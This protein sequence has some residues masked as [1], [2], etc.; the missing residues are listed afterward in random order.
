MSSDKPYQSQGLEPD[1]NLCS[2]CEGLLSKHL[3]P[4]GQLVSLAGIVLDVYN[5]DLVVIVQVITYLLQY[6]TSTQALDDPDSS[7]Q[8]K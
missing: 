4:V 8:M 6:F 1:G 7:P 2:R 3:E 5:N